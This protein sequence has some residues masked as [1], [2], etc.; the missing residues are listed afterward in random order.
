MFCLE[1]LETVITYDS[2][3]H[4][5]SCQS[6]KLQFKVFLYLSENFEKV[7]LTPAFKAQKLK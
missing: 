2:C 3:F 5:L 6:V 7:L 4:I 1:F